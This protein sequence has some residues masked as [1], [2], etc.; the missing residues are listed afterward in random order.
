MAGP[1]F[2]RPRSDGFASIATRLA[3]AFHVGDRIGE[4][5]RCLA[6]E[7]A[8]KSLAAGAIPGRAGFIA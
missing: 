6:R 3:G 2:R 5:G 1:Q 4:V 7:P 8:Y